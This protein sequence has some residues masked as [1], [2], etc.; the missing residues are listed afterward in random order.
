MR[1]LRPSNRIGTGFGKPDGTDFTL[2]N[3]L[4]HGSDS[5]FDTSRNIGCNWNDA[6]STNENNASSVK[7]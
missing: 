3:E 4:R 2:F 1:R 7:S 6:N 5:F